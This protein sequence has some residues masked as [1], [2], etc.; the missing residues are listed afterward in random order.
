M[1]LAMTALL[2]VL[3]FAVFILIDHYFRTAKQPVLQAAPVSPE[4]NEF[5]RPSPVVG[6]FRVPEYLR[7]HP[8]HTWALNESPTLVRVGMDDFAAKVVGRIERIALPQ[9][10]QWVRQG[11]KIWTV[12]RD[13]KSVDMLSP[14]EG[15]VTDINEAAARDPEQAR[16]DPYSEGWLV[17]VHSPDAKI[18]LRNLMSG[19]LAR[20]WTDQCA[21]RLRAL[22]P[23][24]AGALA[25]D[26]GTAIDDVTSSLQD[27]DWTVLTREFFLS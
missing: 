1:R 13:G 20:A 22:M 14:I 15:Q 19:A 16:K 5:A 23:A 9:R 3:M 11:Q 18:N 2:V 4:R 10:G 25:Q 24:P 17:A 8:G 7:Y 6:G 21:A 26:G 12:F 27:Q